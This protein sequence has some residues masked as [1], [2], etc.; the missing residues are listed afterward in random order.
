M[1]SQFFAV[2]LSLFLFVF[3]PGQVTAS[4]LRSADRI[5]VE[6]SLRKMHLFSDGKRIKTYRIALGFSPTGHK[7][8]E[9]DGKTPEGRYTIESKNS[10]S[11]FHL[12]LKVSY[13]SNAD[14][15][16]SRSLGVSPGGDIMIHGFPNDPI[17]FDRVFEVHPLIDWTRGCI[18]V[19]NEEIE[20]IFELVQVGTLIEIKP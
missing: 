16:R 17:K 1:Y 13:P 2:F 20:E 15:A 8:M 7:Q 11:A 19:T 14:I 5:L 18:A 6:K 9:G 10:Q 3:T 4:E 12:S